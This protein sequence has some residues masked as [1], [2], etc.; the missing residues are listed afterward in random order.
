[1]EKWEK[2]RQSSERK[3]KEGVGVSVKYNL[4]F[5]HKIFGWDSIQNILS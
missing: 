1:L 4:T 5:A 2:K 3:T